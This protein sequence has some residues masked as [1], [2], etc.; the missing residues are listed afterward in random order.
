MISYPNNWK[1]SNV[2]LRLR[3]EISI[4]AE[5]TR[6]FVNQAIAPLVASACYA[7][8]GCPGLKLIAALFATA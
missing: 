1:P 5:G 3:R 7:A 4:Q 6:L 8:A 2:A